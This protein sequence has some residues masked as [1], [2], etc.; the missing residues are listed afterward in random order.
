[1]SVFHMPGILNF[2]CSF[3][4]P[5]SPT[6]LLNVSSQGSIF[7]PFSSHVIHS[8][9]PTI[10]TTTHTPQLPHFHLHLTSKPPFLYLQLLAS[11]GRCFPLDRSIQEWVVLGSH[12]LASNLG[13]RW[14]VCLIVFLSVLPLGSSGQI[15]WP[16]R[17][18]CLGSAFYFLCINLTSVLILFTSIFHLVVFILL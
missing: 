6:F 7:G 8:A 13:S 11:P 15:W 9:V 5:G 17:S 16:I 1:M 3:S 10:I 2:L 14:N 12:R 4:F 18:C